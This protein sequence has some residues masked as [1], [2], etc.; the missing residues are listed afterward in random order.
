MDKVDREYGI[1]E[2]T[3]FSGPAKA[4]LTFGGYPRIEVERRSIIVT[5]SYDF[6]D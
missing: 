6:G 1:M 5:E 2:K 4:C 3:S